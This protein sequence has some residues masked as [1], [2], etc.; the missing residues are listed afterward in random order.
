MINGVKCAGKTTNRNCQHTH[1]HLSLFA[2]GDGWRHEVDHCKAGQPPRIKP[3]ARRLPLFMKLSSSLVGVASASRRCCCLLSVVGVGLVALASSSR[4]SW[5]LTEYHYKNLEFCL[6]TWCL[7]L[8]VD[9]VVVLIR[10][11]A[12]Y[13]LTRLR[14]NQ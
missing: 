11:P 3:S 1:D 8:G 12:K 6:S 7:H 5:K 14:W 4:K 13:M 2:L 9:F 10:S